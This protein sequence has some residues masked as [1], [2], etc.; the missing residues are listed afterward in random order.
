[1][2]V[3]I[4]LFTAFFIAQSCLHQPGITQQRTPAY[5]LTGPEKNMLPLAVLHTAGRINLQAKLVRAFI[6]RLILNPQPQANTPAVTIGKII[7]R[8][9][10]HQSSSWLSDV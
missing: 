7:K 5:G 10:W 2:I 3:G 6:G 8:R 9:Q 4:P 1:A